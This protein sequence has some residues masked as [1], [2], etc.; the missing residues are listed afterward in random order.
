MNLAETQVAMKKF[1]I[2]VT[3]I[4]I[5]YY[6]SKFLFFQSVDL[7]RKFNPVKKIDPPATFGMLPKLK[8]AN[9]TVNGNPYYILD[10]IDG[11]LPEFP[12]RLKV[13]K[14]TKPEA[15]LLSEQQIKQIAQDLGFSGSYTSLSKSEFRWVDGT[16]QRTFT[17]HAITKSF[18][19]YTPVTKISTAI[20]QTPSI[21]A[22]DA[23]NKVTSFLRSKGLLSPEDLENIIVTTI[24]SQIS[25]GKMK[26]TGEL[27]TSSKIVKVN[28]Y[29]NIKEGPYTVIG[30]NP[31][32]SLISFHVTNDTGPYKFPLINFTYWPVDYKNGSE[33]YLS[34]VAD[35]WNTV[36]E[37][38]GII[39]YVKLKSGDYYEKL[40]TLNVDK[41]EIRDILIS[42]YEDKELPDYLQPIYVFKGQFTT[43]Q[44]TTKV[45]ETGEIMIYYPAIRGDFV[46]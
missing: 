16:K 9:I 18:Q 29:R 31:N 44:E 25:L 42:Y 26:E 38:K 27:I 30:Q 41:V 40:G 24:P 36:K 32:D 2:G 19:L 10:T 34:S 23:S 5:F 4:T 37:G 21:T 1:L 28:V 20:F 8:M 17:A 39:A 14:V 12:D 11:K 13:Y 46:N 3:T 7:Y 22:D 35:V 6:T 43:T 33:Y 15:T 45:A